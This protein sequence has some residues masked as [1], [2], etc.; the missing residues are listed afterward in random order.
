MKPFIK[1][2]FSVFIFFLFN[3]GKTDDNIN[4]TQVN[5]PADTDTTISDSQNSTPKPNSLVSLNGTEILDAQGNPLF[6]QGVAFG[7]EVWSNPTTE[8]VN[9]HSEIDYER[10]S[11]MGMNAVRFYLNYR[12]F[13]DD[14][15]P[16]VYRQEG[17]DWLD[18]NITWAKKYGVYLVINMH[19]PQGGFQ[20]QGDGDALW[21]VPENQNRLVA[22]WKAIADRY[23]EE[24]QIIGFGLVNEPVPSQ[25]ISQWSSLAQRLINE[26]QSVNPH[27]LL[28]VEK[29]IFVKGNFQLD[30]NLNFPEVEGENIIYEFHGYDPIRYTHQ[31]LNFT[32]L[33]DGGKYPDEAILES[34]E[35]TWETATFGNPSI[36]SQNSDWNYYEGEKY[37]ITDPNIAYVLPAL[38]GAR[39]NGRVYFDDLVINEYDENG[40]FVRVISDL[41][42]NALDSWYYW[43]NNDSGNQGLGAIGHTDNASIFIEGSTDDSNLSNPSLRFIPTLNYHYQ[44][45]GWMKGENVAADANCHFR[46]DLFSAKGEILQRNKKY[47]RYEVEKFVNWAEQKN[48]ALYMGEFGT[49]YPTFKN[50]KGGATYVEDLLDLATEHKIHFTYHTYHED[51]FGIYLGH[52]TPDPANV[53]QAL[54]DL[55]TRK[56]K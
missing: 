13:E 12:L 32:G 29:A 50:N 37:Q 45:N 21:D 43:S 19:V 9:H 26:I 40:N 52:Q 36:P 55:F 22:L 1:I 16:Y 8:P 3:C 35:G 51:S 33:P 53:N 24:G 7:N 31:L 47:L 54:I 42:L 38:I 56:L 27:H 28:F 23:K 14:N 25:A 20:S 17:W 39:V 2:S 11:D 34:A 5:N 41:N 48:A 18:K 15:N 6:L 10:V 49:G 46:L 4:D 44:I 30:E